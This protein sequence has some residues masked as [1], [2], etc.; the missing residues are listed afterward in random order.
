MVNSLFALFFYVINRAADIRQATY[1]VIIY[2]YV[3]YAQYCR[4]PFLS[5]L[6]ARP[7][8]GHRRYCCCRSLLNHRPVIVCCNFITG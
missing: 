8:E 2:N 5:G 7:C 6:E 3:V 1:P 4:L